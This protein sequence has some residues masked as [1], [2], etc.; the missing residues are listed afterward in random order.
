M[1]KILSIS[2]KLNNL[3]GYGLMFSSFNYFA[4]QRGMSSYT[5]DA[6][7]NDNF[8]RGSD[9]LKPNIIKEDRI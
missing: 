6:D 9:R 2:L 8:R 3:G 4:K 1:G 5:I 7:G